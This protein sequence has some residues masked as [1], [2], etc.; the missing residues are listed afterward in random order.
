M[1]AG[2]ARSGKRNRPG[3]VGAGAGQ[4]LAV[5]VIQLGRRG[6]ADRNL[7]ADVPAT[8]CMLLAKFEFVPSGGVWLEPGLR[9]ADAQVVRGIAG[10]ARGLVRADVE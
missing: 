3:L 8:R 6:T 10:F 5:G 4:L 9:A 1:V 7:H 2:G